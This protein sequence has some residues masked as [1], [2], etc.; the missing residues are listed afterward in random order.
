MIK[1]WRWW[2]PCWGGTSWLLLVCNEEPSLP[3]W[4]PEAHSEMLA[5]DDDGEDDDDIDSHDD[6]G[7]HGDGCDDDGDDDEPIMLEKR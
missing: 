1:M 3:S 5:S 2:W 4:A 6:D 7:D